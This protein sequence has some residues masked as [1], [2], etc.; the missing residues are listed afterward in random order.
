MIRIMVD[1]ETASVEPD[2]AILQL[3]AADFSCMHRF[4]VGISV[5][6]NHAWKRKFDPETLAWWDKQDRT[7]RNK[8]FSGTEA[9]EE[10]LYLFRGY[11]NIVTYDL[12]APYELWSNGSD[13]DLVILKN[14]YMQ[15]KGEYPFDFRSHRCFRTLKAMAPDEYNDMQFQGTK[16]DALSDAIHQ[17]KLASRYLADLG[18]K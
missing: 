10:A 2:A 6:N 9:L 17:A 13:F 4:D 16:H 1:I 7:L 8:V 5:D 14:A 11:V 18:V 3:S 12:T 15:I